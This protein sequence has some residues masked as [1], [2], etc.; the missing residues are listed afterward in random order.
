MNVK[1]KNNIKE[2]DNKQD[3]FAYLVTLNSNINSQQLTTLTFSV[4]L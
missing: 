1:L 3:L 2:V 4:G